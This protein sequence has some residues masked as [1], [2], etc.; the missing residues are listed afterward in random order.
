MPTATRRSDRSC[1]R[2]RACGGLS[3][4]AP[5]DPGRASAPHTATAAVRS[6]PAPPRSPRRT[7]RPHRLSTGIPPAPQPPGLAQRRADPRGRWAASS[8][9]RDGVADPLRASASRDGAHGRMPVDAADRLARGGEEVAEDD[10]A[11]QMRRRDH[12]GNESRR[13]LLAADLQRAPDP[14][15]LRRAVE[16]G[17]DFVVDD[18]RAES[19][20]PAQMAGRSRSSTPAAGCGFR[21]RFRPPGSQRRRR[22][23]SDGAPVKRTVRTPASDSASR[24]SVEPVKSSP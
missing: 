17:A 15:D 11:A 21:R 19:A 5:R 9:R 23:F 10:V 24:T 14:A 22:H 6:P 2:R 8:V 4:L 12:D 1:P 3:R 18:G 16:R 13:Q 20:E 7:A